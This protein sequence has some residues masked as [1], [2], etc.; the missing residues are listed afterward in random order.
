MNRP[1]MNFQSWAAGVLFAVL[2]GIVGYSLPREFGGAGPSNAGNE[3]ATDYTRPTKMKPIEPGQAPSFSPPAEDKLPDGDF[4]KMVRLGEDIFNNT[5]G[6]ARAFVGNDLRC[7]NCH[8]D[9]GRLA[10]SAPLW[11]AY[12]AYPAFRSKNGH[13]NTFA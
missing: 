1:G 5:A 4:G 2:A 11:A 3:S 12:V 6:Q 9:A 13:V 8:L 10:N 7:A